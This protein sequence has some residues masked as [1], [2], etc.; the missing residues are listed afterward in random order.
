MSNF[1]NS[2][3][4]TNKCDLFTND[5]HPCLTDELKASAI[6]SCDLL[7]NKNDKFKYCFDMIDSALFYKAC[8]WDYC[9]AASK[10]NESIDAAL[11]SS[12][13]AM[14]RECSDNFV[15]VLWRNEK[16]CRMLKF[17]FL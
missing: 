1:I 14:S 12:F 5:L 2:F 16:R 3:I 9:T 4:L 17:L 8:L 15:N 7:N 11:C 13:D 6:S 10:Q